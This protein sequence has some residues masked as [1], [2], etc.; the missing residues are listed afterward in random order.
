MKLQNHTLLRRNMA[1]S[2][3]DDSHNS[4]VA[5][6][7]SNDTSE[8]RQQPGQA[9]VARMRALRSKRRLQQQQS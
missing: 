5:Y 8:K 6:Q 2:R 7:K 3:R 1:L 9:A 4:R